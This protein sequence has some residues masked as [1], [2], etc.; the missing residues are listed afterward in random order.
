[1]DTN[2]ST[3][4]IL[5]FTKEGLDEIGSLTQ[6]AAEAENRVVAYRDG[7]GKEHREK[8]AGK[9]AVVTGITESV[10]WLLMGGYEYCEAFDRLVE[11]KVV[12][13][14]VTLTEDRLGRKT[15]KVWA[16]HYEAHTRNQKGGG[17]T[18]RLLDLTQF[19]AVDESS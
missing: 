11:A 2:V 8:L 17:L 18:F 3:K 14:S 19:E 6:A 15:P 4:E 5:S 13:I 16:E 12:I 7:F 1:M 9:S 10:E